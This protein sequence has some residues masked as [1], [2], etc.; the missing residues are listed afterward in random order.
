MYTAM[1]NGELLIKTTYMKSAIK[2]VLK[3]QYVVPVSTTMRRNINSTQERFFL[4][5]IINTCLKLVS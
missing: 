2:K 4:R 1:R 3:A 5:K